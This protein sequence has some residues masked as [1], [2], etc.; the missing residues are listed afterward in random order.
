MLITLLF[1]ASIVAGSALGIAGV[2]I[3]A[4]PLILLL[5]GAIFFTLRFD[6]LSAVRRAPRTIL[7]AIVTNFA[8]IPAVALPITMLLPSD[9][10]RLGVLVYCLAP[11][12][13]WFLGF[14]RLAGGD[15]T[16]GAALIPL[17]MLI[18]LVM[19]PVWMALFAGESVD[20]MPATA[21]AVLAQWFLLPAS[22]GLAARYLLPPHR[23]ARAIT[24]VDR[25]V[26]FA[27]AAVIVA[28]FS[29]NVTTI[30]ADPGAFISVLIA[31]FAFFVATFAIGETI[32]RIAR[33]DHAAHALVTMTTSARNAPLMLAVTMVALPDQPV[34]H[35]AIVLGMLIEFPHLT[36]ITQVL[37]RERRLRSAPIM[38]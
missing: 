7:I 15:T 12:T 33:L 2:S 23:R 3:P 32:S 27:V 19:Y 5:V 36:V 29:G 10:L 30:L 18:Q 8:L 16:A 35:A 17:Q 21:G 24:A 4:D 26:P 11:C 28:V 13:D 20:W 9:A 6:G 34:T 31:V 25:C 38:R 1:A 22:I 14:T 37:R